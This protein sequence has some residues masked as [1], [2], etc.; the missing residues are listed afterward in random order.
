MQDTGKTREPPVD[1]TTSL[2]LKISSL[3]QIQNRAEEPDLNLHRTL[4]W[5]DFLL[6]LHE[7]TMQMEEKE[8]FRYVLDQVVRLTG[9]TFGFCHLVADDQR[10]ISM[11]IGNRE[12]LEHGKAFHDLR[13]PL[14]PARNG[15]DWFDLKH[16]TV[17]NDF[18][19]IPDKEKPS[20]L[21]SPVFRFMSVPVFEREKLRIVIGM[22]NK[23]HAYDEQDVFHARSV[24]GHLRTILERRRAEAELRGRE[25]RLSLIL[26]VTRDGIWD[27]NIAAGNGYANPSYFTMLGYDPG[28]VSLE[29]DIWETYIHPDDL[30]RV[31]EVFNRLRQMPSP[32]Q[33]EIQSVEFRM[34][35]KNGG[36][37]WI[38]GRGKAVEWDAGGRPVRMV[39][40]HTDIEK[41]KRAEEELRESQRRLADIIEFLPDATLVIGGDGR[42]LAWNRAIEVMTGT[43]KEDMLG[44]GDFEYAL[45]FY[46]VRRPILIDLALNQ[47]KELEKELYTAVHRA[48]DTLFGEARTSNLPGNVTLSA[49]A[50]VLRDS[51]GNLVGAIECI[52]DM[53]ERVHLESQLRQAQKME[54]IGTL[55]GG[56]AHDFNNILASIIGYTELAMINR[57]KANL[58]GGNLEQVLRACERAKNLVNQILILSRQRE[59]ERKPVDVRGIV[60]EA[61]KLMRAS[62]PT[63]IK[64]NQRIPRE[65]LTVMA[66]PTQI[67]QI[68]LNL[69]TNAAHAMRDKKGGVLDVHL[70]SIDAPDAVTSL[71]EG[72]EAG[73]YAHLVVSDNGCGIEPD[74]LDKIF[75]PFFT[76]KGQADG[77]GLGLSVVYGIVDS[78]GGAIR[79]K[80]DPGQGT[81][82]HVYLPAMEEVKSAGERK[83]AQAVP[84]GRESILLVD[85]EELLVA[86][87]EQYLRVLGYDAVSVTDSSEALDMVAKNPRRFHLLVTDMTMPQMTGLNLSREVLSINPEVPI[88]LC[89]GFNESIT[90]DEAKKSGIR[91]FVLK[92][93]PLQQLAHLVRRVLDGI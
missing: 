74:I 82:F 33:E 7:E 23:A 46:G 75:N 31:R 18:S 91:E 42:V 17:Y 76:T 40:T 93:I 87:M 10:S 34:K 6:S 50:S 38:L 80:S 2:R 61:L 15:A 16:P 9:S 86:A 72:D 8:L 27:W 11:T 88:I 78:Y 60:K 84:G 3:D 70:S 53:T 51:R 47:D 79:V 62:L 59:Q 58:Q 81:A 35:M 12:A 25:E 92:P 49:T 89:T 44:K 45:P 85:D 1:E 28:E 56:I 4:A 48:G 36:W 83:V 55:A 22:G 20:D 68:I 43:G 5:K 39:G 37:R 41:W 29:Y 63:T 73:S 69:C 67:H 26:D 77:T 24:A 65:P 14:D 57:N 32:R 30:P 64:I 90:E 66:D 54:A 21:Y 52:R 13:C 19:H 71:Y